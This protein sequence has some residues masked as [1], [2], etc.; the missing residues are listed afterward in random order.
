ML[1]KIG[2]TT[3]ADRSTRAA[4]PAGKDARQ[5][6][7]DAAAGDMRHSF[8]QARL[9]QRPHGVKVGPVWRKQ[10]LADGRPAS[11]TI[12]SAV[13]PDRSKST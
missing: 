1:L 3:Q 7:G 12:V 10:R 11:G 2:G 9:D 4:Q 13:S 8:D 6:L 5:I